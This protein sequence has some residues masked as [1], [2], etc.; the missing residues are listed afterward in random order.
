MKKIGKKKIESKKTVITGFDGK[1]IEFDS[2]MEAAYYQY[3]IQNKEGLNIRNIELQK[4]FILMGDL[5]LVCFVCRGKKKVTSTKTGNL[6][7][8]RKCNATGL[9]K[10]NGAKY[11]ADFV[12]TYNNGYEEVIDVKGYANDSF[13]LRKRLF[14][15]QFYMPLIVVTRKGKEWVRGD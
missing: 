4:E 7:K 15:H 6:I 14:E 13:S 8:C 9:R 11:T 1:E 12:V 5:N 10:S 2:K 3:L